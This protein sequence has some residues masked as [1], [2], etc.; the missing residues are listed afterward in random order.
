[1]RNSS[2]SFSLHSF[3]IS[4]RNPQAPSLVLIP[5]L[6]KDAIIIAVVSFA[7][8]M[9]LAKIYAKKF[10]YTVNSNQELAA[11]GLCNVSYKMF[12]D[13]IVFCL[14]TGDWLILWIICMCRFFIPN[15]C[16]GEYWCSNSSKMTL[17]VV[18]W[19]YFELYI[20]VRF[21]FLC[22]STC[23]HLTNRIV[24]WILAKGNWLLSTNGLN[25]KILLGLLSIDYCRRIERFIFANER[26]L[27]N[28][29]RHQIR[30]GKSK[31]KRSTCWI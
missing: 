23:D 7:I 6:I 24:V 27:Y 3:L 16:L 18:E 28:W 30:S 2:N 11:Y 22:I 17:F 5:S 1:M 12:I 9:S 8:C 21:D 4:F 10:K 29:S 31:Q 14:K 13:T 26:Y 20:G 19:T 15:K 25:T